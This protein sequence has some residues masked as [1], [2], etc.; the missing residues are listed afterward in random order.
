MAED[1]SKD[2]NDLKAKYSFGKDRMGTIVDEPI[3][4]KDHSLDAIRMAFNYMQIEMSIS[5]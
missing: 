4:G 5:I 2:W 1:K 3:K